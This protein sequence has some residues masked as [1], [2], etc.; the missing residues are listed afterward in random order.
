MDAMEDRFV[1]FCQEENF[2]QF[3]KSII[4]R[5]YINQ[6]KS[7]R[8]MQADLIS[9]VTRELNQQLPGLLDRQNNDHLRSVKRLVQNYESEITNK[10]DASNHQVET[11]LQQSQRNFKQVFKEHQRQLT[12]QS[13]QL[14]NELS[15]QKQS[16]TQMITDQDSL[17]HNRVN[18]QVKQVI[19]KI[20]HEEG[21]HTINQRYF[22]I[23]KEDTQREMESFRQEWV[24]S[25][26]KF[27]IETQDEIKSF[28]RDNHEQLA[29][30][31]DRGNLMINDINQRYQEETNEMRSLLQI[32]NQN[33]DQIKNLQ[34]RAKKIYIIIFF[35][36]I[37]Y[38]KTQIFI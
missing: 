5:D 2:Q 14:R 36:V 37:F 34:S 7:S 31:R 18:Q 13:D 24:T 28:K 38:L 12:N 1:A 30:T 25:L 23:F 26:R 27:R 3:V 4:D 35:T 21:Y 19:E 20:I 17:I 32:C 22:N 10:I 33:Q 8:K 29:V 9:L 15:R 6:H 11:S 16:M